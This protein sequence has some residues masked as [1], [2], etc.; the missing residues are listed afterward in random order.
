[1]PQAL[2]SALFFAFFF[3]APNPPAPPP[4]LPPE[5]KVKTAELGRRVAALRA[6]K[7]NP[8]LLADVEIYHKAG[9]WLEKFPEETFSPADLSSFLAVLD[10]G[11]ERA[12]ALERGEAPW[13]KSGLRRVHGFY[14]ALDG[15]TQLYG[16]RVP[17]SYDAS[18]PARLYVWLHGRDQKN[19][20]L[21]FIHSFQR[22]TKNHS[23]PEEIGQLQLDVYG[24]WNGMAYHIVGEADVMEAIA[25]VKRRYKIDENRIILRGFSMGGCGAWHIAMH[26]PSMWAA[27]EIGAG[28]WPRRAMMDGFPPYQAG[29]LRIWENILEWSLNFFNLPLAGHGGEKESGTSSIPGPPPGTPTRGQLESSIRVREQLAVEGFESEGDSYEMRAQGTDAHF[30]VSKDTGHSTSPEVRAKLDAF[31]KKYGDRGRVS[32]DHLRFLTYTT[33]Y[34]KSH[35]ATIDL[36]NS[37]YERAEVEAIRTDGR[38]KYAITTKNIGRLTLREMENAEEVTIDGQTVRVAGAPQLSFARSA[39]GWEPSKAMP[40]GLHKVH[41]LQGPI[42]D[43]FLDPFLLV[44][45]TGTPW[46]K[47]AHE[48][49]LRILA[50]FDKLYAK[51]LRAHPRVKDDKDV[52][53]QDIERYHIVAFGDPG[54]NRILAR[55][56][57]RLPLEWTKDRVGFGGDIRPASEGLPALIYPNPLNPKKYV[58]VNS[59]LTSEERE[60]RGEYQ[61]PRLG[62]YALLKIS[63]SGDF[64]DI[65]AAGLFDEK[66][67]IKK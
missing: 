31:L 53:A 7:A 21:K 65:L 16:V 30:F 26:Y 2:V 55:L 18:K 24:R 6:K 62:D 49:S 59:G 58:V 51:H 66:W 61:L 43:A 67:Q 50:R 64:P 17:E 44:R 10:Q 46:N 25:E 42:E 19:S 56:A 15:S 45:P 57:S 9:Q 23:N 4:P 12:A 1:M 60:I 20:E 28:T 63:E 14:S 32:P 54:S 34:N 33:R 5:A 39:Q 29:P 40:A 22:V 52:T 11:L 37:L 38:R 47:A 27:A 35:W 13:T 8:D 48:Q 41:G 3:Q 36:M